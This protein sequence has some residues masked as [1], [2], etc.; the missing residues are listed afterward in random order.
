TALLPS[1]LCGGCGFGLIIG[2][3]TTLILARVEPNLAG[4]AA[5]VLATAQQVGGAL[6][7]AVVGAL[8]FGRIEGAAG[9]ALTRGALF[10]LAT[11]TA[12]RFNLAAFVVV[13]GLFFLLPT[14]RA[15]PAQVAAADTVQERIPDAI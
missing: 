2:P 5:G 15:Q 9:T 6:G 14:P 10:S 13:L 1:L 11:Q 7:I 4:A 8:L 12:L 3:L